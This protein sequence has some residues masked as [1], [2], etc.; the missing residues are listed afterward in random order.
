MT[1]KVAVPGDSGHDGDNDEYGSLIPVTP[2][3]KRI[4][5]DGEYGRQGHCEL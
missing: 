5:D 4:V 3:D 2:S 1:N